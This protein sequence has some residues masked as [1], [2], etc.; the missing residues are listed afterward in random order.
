V[1]LGV[2]LSLAVISL[3]AC[4]AAAESGRGEASDG[5]VSLPSSSSASGKPAGGPTIVTGVLTFDDI[6]S[7]CTYLQTADGRRF[8]V[9][10][11]EGWAIDRAGAKLDGPSGE[12]VRAG[13]SLTVKGSIARDRSSI[14]QVG[15]IFEASSVSPP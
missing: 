10:Y 11:P 7:G 3:S 5:I 9:I 6:E 2:L 15:P 13:E 4:A 14:C 12:V 8:E 1:R